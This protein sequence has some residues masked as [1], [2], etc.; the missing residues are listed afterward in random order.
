MFPKQAMRSTLKEINISFFKHTE[1]DLERV[2]LGSSKHFL[3][4]SKAIGQFFFLP[5]IFSPGWGNDLYRLVFLL[6]CKNRESK[7]FNYSIF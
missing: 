7:A 4:S 3:A 2:Y 5:T 6:A 1:A